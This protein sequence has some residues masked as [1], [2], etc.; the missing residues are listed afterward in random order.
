M[1]KAPKVSS[2]SSKGHVIKG[3]DCLNLYDRETGFRFI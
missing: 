1:Y 2:I 3:K